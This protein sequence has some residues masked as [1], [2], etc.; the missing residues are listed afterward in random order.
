M[1]PAPAAAGGKLKGLPLAF[2]YFFFK[3]L[4]NSSRSFF[5]L[6]FVSVIKFMAFTVITLERDE[7]D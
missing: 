7:K 1:I 2:I 4:W 6:C 3:S 5:Y